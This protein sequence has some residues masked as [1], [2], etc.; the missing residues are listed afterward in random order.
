MAKPPRVL[1]SP[2]FLSFQKGSVGG[3]LHIQGQLDIQQLLV[4]T[5]QPGHVLLGLL[6]GI[7]Q[8]SQLV[9][10]IFE[11][12]LTTLLGIADGLL[13]RRDLRKK[14]SHITHSAVT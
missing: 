3:D 12:V 10:G 9:L 2:A 1:S 5:Q 7:L 13:Q 14:S 8:L 6:Q 4:V 11:G